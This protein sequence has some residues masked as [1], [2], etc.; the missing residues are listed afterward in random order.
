[1]KTVLIALLALLSSTAVQ[2]RG[3][4]DRVVLEGH[5]YDAR[6]YSIE[7]VY[8][9]A[10]P[11]KNYPEAPKSWTILKKLRVTLNKEVI[12]VPEAA[13]SD[14]FWPAMPERPEL[15]PDGSMTLS[16]G[17]SSGEQSYTV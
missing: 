10:P 14:L 13:I 6:L 8:A 11:Q 5:L 7:F 9:P 2:A 17:G 1:M 3:N 15:E 12:D 16:F 4:L